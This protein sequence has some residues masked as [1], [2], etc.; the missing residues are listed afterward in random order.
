M[1]STNG[2]GPRRAVLYARVSTDEQARSGYS[3]AQQLEALRAHCEREGY[4]VLEEVSDP[5]QSG[6]SLERPG[7]D[8][9]RDLVAAGGVSV[10]LAQDRDRF[11]REPAY[12]Y[13]LRR[14]FEEHGTKLRSLNDREDE[15]PEGEL[16]DGI[17]D[18]L[19]KYERAK[20]TERT[21][22]GKL[23]K[24]REG[25][26]IATNR[27]HYG[28]RYNDSR[29]N[30]VVVEEEM[31]VVARIFRM[32]GEE[33][34]SL[35]RVKRALE[36]EG[37]PSPNGK[38]AWGKFFIREC[39]KDDAYKAHTHEELEALVEK[40]QMAPEVAARLD[41][42]KRYGVWWFN[43]HRTTT[44]QV[45][46]QDGEGRKRYRRRTSYA[47][48]PE[49]EWIA[50]PVPDAG[51][52]R[53]WVDRAREAVAKNKSPSRNGGRDWELSGGIA[54]CAECGWTMKTATVTSGNSPKINLYYRCSQVYLNPGPRRVLQPQVASGRQAGAVGV[55]LRLR[56]D[57]GPRDAA[58]RLRQDGRAQG[59]GHAGGP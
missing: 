13:L 44:T 3:L 45:A 54:R 56:R 8:R 24:A 11:A 58:R 49:S 28:F 46:V 33:G 21:R 23:K 18:Q 6:A 7:M 50:V 36:R 15:S 55:G 27:P 38:R 17:F 40:G 25:K 53:E 37:I 34:A 52:P 16:T 22:R 32:I 20:M 19:A 47:P 1:P 48:K 5:G 59:P 26:V 51:I 29:D 41:P 39:I 12:H 2:H 57:E 43:R 31:R 35:L 30:Y 9:V 42:A 10:V 4:E 14:E